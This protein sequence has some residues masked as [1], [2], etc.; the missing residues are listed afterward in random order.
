MVTIQIRAND[1]CCWCPCRVWLGCLANTALITAPLVMAQNP[2]KTLNET[3]QEAKD[4]RTG[5]GKLFLVLS[6]FFFVEGLGILIAPNLTQ[7]VS[8][9]LPPLH[10]L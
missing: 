10:F 3:A 9:L 2:V 4:V 5:C 6:A 7:R 1:M 8:Q